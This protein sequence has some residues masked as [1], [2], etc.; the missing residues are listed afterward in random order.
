MPVKR[1]TNDAE[2]KAK[3]DFF[4]VAFFVAF[5]FHRSPLCLAFLF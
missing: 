1:L 3:N 2:K 4:F 5:F